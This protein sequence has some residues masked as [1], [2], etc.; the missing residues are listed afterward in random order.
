MMSSDVCPA[1]LVRGGHG[2]AAAAVPALTIAKA[3]ATR[4][5]IARDR[6]LSAPAGPG[7]RIGL[8]TVSG[9]THP[10]TAIAE[11]R[12]RLAPVGERTTRIGR[13]TA[14]IATRCGIARQEGPVRMAPAPD[15]TRPA[16]IPRE[17]TQIKPQE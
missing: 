6:G 10:R 5:A 7:I 2:A 16:R 1:V 8:A 11:V 12:A 9:R 14:L 4:I 3:R 13:E 15:E 17:T